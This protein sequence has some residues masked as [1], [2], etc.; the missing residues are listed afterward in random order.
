MELQTALGLSLGTIPFR[1]LGV[2]LSSKKLS[3]YQCKP[4][5]DKVTARIQG[6][7]AKYLSYAGRLQLVKSVLFGIQTYWAQIF[8]LPKKVVKDIEARFRAFLW[9]GTATPSKRNLVSWDQVCLPKVNGGWNVLSLPEWNIAAISKLLWDLAHK[10]DTLWVKW[11]H[12]Y[13]FKRRQCWEAPI[14]HSCSWVLRNIFKCRDIVNSVGGWSAVTHNGKLKTHKLYALLRPQA[15]KV[16]WRRLIC[17][18]TATPCSVFITWL[19]LNNKLMTRDRLSLW[20]Q[21]CSVICP[22]CNIENESVSHLFFQWDYSA[23]VWMR[24]LHL[25][26]IQRPVLQLEQEVQWLSRFC[27]SKNIRHKICMMLFSECLYGIWLQRN[28]MVFQHSCKPPDVVFRDAVFRMSCK[29]S[30]ADQN[31]LIIE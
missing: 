1:Y 27:R 30:E 29:C 23:A 12:I 15:P 14:P 8:V 7:T 16:D 4:L 19:A 22:L 28:S 26:H 20:F 31:M 2:P 10:A 18:N 5:V 13:Y 17:N 6:W 11:V 25:L 21:G 3:V 24:A 9:T